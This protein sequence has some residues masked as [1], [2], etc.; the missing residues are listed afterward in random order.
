VNPMDPTQSQATAKHPTPERIMEVGLSCFSSKVLLTAVELRVFTV[1]SKQQ[2]TGEELGK[3]LS[4]HPR[5]IYD[6][7][8]ALVA[9]G[10]LRRE[11]TGS[12]G[13]YSNSPESAL[14]LDRSE[15]TYM[16]GILE[17]VNARLYGFWN[18][19]GTALKTGEPQNEL[20]R[21]EK[22]LFETLYSDPARLEQFMDA[23]R[24]ISGPNVQALAEKFDFSKYQTLCDVGG[25]TAL[26]STVVAQRHPHLK[27][28]SFDLPEV[29]PIAKRW[30]A[31]AG[32]SDRVSTAAGSF[33]TQPL[34]RADVITMGM[35]LHDWNLEKK[36][37]LI[38]LAYDALPPGG[39]FIA[40]ENL[41]DDERRKN[42]FGLLMSLNMLI[43][44]GDA[45]DYTSADFW[46]WCREAGFSRYEVMPL[47][48][49]CSAAIAYK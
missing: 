39:A 34:P 2:M 10:F 19:L 11:G 9:L 6:F 36:K 3:V 23:M 33:L 25:A 4:L 27:C 5:G 38:R 45:F 7:L 12:A 40:I 31:R 46:S 49:P 15:P 17:M 28:L 42:T 30:I 44:V 22:P 14:F 35:I 47:A 43:E 1:L 21:S 20:K 32:L 29:E 18:D 16:G 48:G 26:L 24:G 13:R 37:Y 41:I 8:D